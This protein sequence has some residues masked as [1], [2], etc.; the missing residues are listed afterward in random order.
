[1]KRHNGSIE[2]R[3]VQRCRLYW[4]S[5]GHF[6]SLSEVDILGILSLLRQMIHMYVDRDQTGSASCYWIWVLVINLW[7]PQQGIGQTSHLL[8]LSIVPHTMAGN[9]LLVTSGP[10]RMILGGPAMLRNEGYDYSFQWK[11]GLWVGGYLPGLNLAIAAVGDESEQIAQYQSGPLD[12]ATGQ[13]DKQAVAPFQDRVWRITA[14]EVQAF[15]YDVSDGVVDP[16]TYPSIFA[17]PGYGNPYF[18]AFNGFPFPYLEEMVAPFYDQNKD[19]IYDPMDGDHPNDY[20]S[21]LPDVQTE[22]VYSIFHMGDMDDPALRSSSPIP[23]NIHVLR[24]PLRCPGQGANANRTIL[25]YLLVHSVHNQPLDSLHIGFWTRPELECTVKAGFEPEFHTPYL[26]SDLDEC[27]QGMIFFDQ[28]YAVHPQA[29]TI[30]KSDLREI[31]GAMYFLNQPTPGFPAGITKPET[32]K[33][34]Y[35]LLTGSWKDGTAL[36]SGGIGYNVLSQGNTSG[37]FTDPPGQGGWEMSDEL[38]EA[39]YTYLHRVKLDQDLKPGQWAYLATI[40][41]LYEYPITDGIALYSSMKNYTAHLQSDWSFDWPACEDG[42]TDPPNDHK[43]WPGDANLDGQ[44]NGADFILVRHHLGEEGLPGVVPMSWR[45]EGRDP[46]N[47]NSVVGQDLVHLDG[48]GNGLVDQED[49][50]AVAL[51]YWHCRFDLDYQPNLSWGDQFRLAPTS[52]SVEDTLWIGSMDSTFW[53]FPTLNAPNPFGIWF[54]MDHPNDLTVEGVFTSQPHLLSKV[55]PRRTDLA[56]TGPSQNS[57]WIPSYIR[58]DLDP[59]LA[60]QESTCLEVRPMDAYTYSPGTLAEM[61]LSTRSTWICREPVTST[62]SEG[63]AVMPFLITPNPT[64]GRIALRDDLGSCSLTV[65][66]AIGQQV[67]QAEGHVFDLGGLSTGQY[68]VEI[69]T[70]D[71]QSWRQSLLMMR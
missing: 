25:T 46:W 13:V 27:D 30:D 2:F 42:V 44:V 62:G 17:W 36:S 33:E 52:T 4:S 1:M 20:L 56:F 50:F 3:I 26:Y 41:S 15:R 47:V 69:R 38:A 67:Y 29:F 23:L 35:R 61:P 16:R 53:L 71:G 57:P 70:M 54:G 37:P 34:Y 60:F 10:G 39:G 48:S 63:N 31:G 14:G 21:T 6:R 11:K 8:D 19:G 58:F 32:A 18:E 24:S 45:Q 49:V 65:W 68:Q 43:V 7:L 12:P 22:I 9:D 55:D 51:N 40:S 59:D 66:D 5:A 28:V 64:T